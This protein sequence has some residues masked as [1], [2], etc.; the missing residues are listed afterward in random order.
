[1][2]GEPRQRQL[3]NNV[4]FTR[5]WHT[6]RGHLTNLLTTPRPPHTKKPQSKCWQNEHNYLWLSRQLRDLLF[7][8][9]RG[10]TQKE[11]PHRQMKEKGE[12]AR[13]N[14]DNSRGITMKQYVD[15]YNSMWIGYQYRGS[16]ALKVFTTCRDILLHY[17]NTTLSTSFATV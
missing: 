10:G 3:A 8:M 15:K 17:K 6:H 9:R 7:F 5:N 13:E 14:F 1:M 12:G 11:W 4:Q 2:P 16:Q